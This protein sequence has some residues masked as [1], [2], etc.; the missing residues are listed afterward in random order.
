MRHFFQSRMGRSVI[1]LVVLALGVHFL[2]SR[3][4]LHALQMTFGL[5]PMLQNTAGE[6]PIDVSVVKITDAEYRDYFCGQSPLD[7]RGVLALVNAVREKLHPAVIGVDLDTSD[8]K[9]G[10]I[11]ATCARANFVCTSAAGVVD[12]GC[13]A[14]AVSKLVFSKR[15]RAMDRM[16]ERAADLA[17]HPPAGSPSP[18]TVVWAQVPG[19]PMP[20]SERKEWWA[21]LQRAWRIVWRGEREPETVLPLQPIVGRTVR[22][23]TIFSGIPRFPLDPDGVVRRYQRRYRVVAE[24]AGAGEPTEMSSLPHA[25]LEACESCV[26]GDRRW[27][28]EEKNH[29]GEDLILKFAAGAHAFNPLDGRY[30]LP[31]LGGSTIP[32]AQ[33]A[34][35]DATLALR[36]TP[37]V[38]I[39]GTYKGAR[40][41]YRTPL[42]EM[43][44]VEL[45]AQA[46]ETELHEG[47]EE[48][49]DFW[50]LVVDILA[51]ALV[52]LLWKSTTLA[53]SMSVR[54]FFLVSLVVLGV[55]FGLFSKFLFRHGIWIDSVAIVFG[56]FIHQVW[57][58]FEKIEEHE[59]TIEEQEHIIA[60]LEQQIE[61]SSAKDMEGAGKGP[62]Q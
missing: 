32:Q 37:I 2:E 14:G 48:T 22:A 54:T 53:R 27:W 19:D 26:A 24:N 49:G 17:A 56:V 51:G 42:G 5:D 10:E 29:S 35:I 59:E 15:D 13:L 16:V 39:G 50:K 30:V 34:D 1:V 23:D 12:Q 21:P 45:L 61:D 31:P 28:S 25:M 44:G 52:I 36:P 41:V 60:R 18:T 55:G 8:W 11:P 33:Q 43:A 40:D 62:G 9:P 7:G 3:G 46:I 58:E 47:V 20:A 57:E 38:L 4:Y 6:T